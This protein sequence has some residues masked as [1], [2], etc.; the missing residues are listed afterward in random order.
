MGKPQ[1]PNML[2]MNKGPQPGPTGM[3][4]GPQPGPPGMNSGPQ[5][6]P[7]GGMNLGPQPGP[8]GMNQGPK[9]GMNQ[10]PP[11]PRPNSSNMPDLLGGFGGPPAN[12]NKKE[13]ELLMP[14]TSRQNNGRPS[15]PSQPNLNSSFS[16][17]GID[18][19]PQKGPNTIV[20][21]KSSA[22]SP[23]PMINNTIN[24][25]KTALESNIKDQENMISARKTDIELASKTL[26]G[27]KDT[28]QKLKTELDKLNKQYQEI[29]DNI[30]KEASNVS[31]LTNKISTANNNISNAVNNAK[32]GIQSI[33]TQVQQ[34]QQNQPQQNQPQIQP[35]QQNQFPS[36]GMMGGPAGGAPMP[37]ANQFDTGNMNFTNQNPN[38]FTNKI[39]ADHNIGGGYGD[40]QP[41]PGFQRQDSFDVS[42]YRAPGNAGPGPDNFNSN[43]G[44][45]F[46]TQS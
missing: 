12:E 34:Q 15:A 31:S 19:T 17:T 6:G 32:T 9:P 4:Q 25:A 14:N 23:S 3:N 22:P 46:N 11:S 16:S 21:T 2:D 24:T 10:P 27:L 37:Q 35:P 28:S 39:V 1:S 45:D 7:P 38:A 18:I 5:P 30:V 33:K 43:Y 41:N 20:G 8:P 40:S 42:K 36:G 26:V 13:E 44:G 29:M